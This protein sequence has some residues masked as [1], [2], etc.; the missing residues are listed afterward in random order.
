MLGLT[1]W[2]VPKY[3]GNGASDARLSLT[4]WRRPAVAHDGGQPAV[5]AGKSDTEPSVASIQLT[6][7]RIILKAN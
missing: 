2:W 3:T 7:F 5:P 4:F 1:N 6:L